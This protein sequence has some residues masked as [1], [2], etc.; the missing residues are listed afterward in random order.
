MIRG[1]PAAVLALAWLLAG[2]AGAA[3]LRFDCGL[4]EAPPGG[5]IAGPLVLRLDPA[6]GT[7]RVTDPLTRFYAGGPVT[8]E[9]APAGQGWRLRWRLDGVQRAGAAP[10]VLRYDA[11]LRGGALKITARAG[12]RGAAYHARGQCWPQPA[13]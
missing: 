5:A 8:A 3:P 11:W 7:A 9:L 12:Q 4:T 13:P 6:R 10:Q 2:G 1:A